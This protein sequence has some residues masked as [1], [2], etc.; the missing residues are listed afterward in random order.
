MAKKKTT[1][2]LTE[3]SDRWLKEYAKKEGISKN[4]VIQLLLNKELLAH[5]KNKQEE[6]K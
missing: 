2:Y 6:T 1:I 5:D 4:N 3:E